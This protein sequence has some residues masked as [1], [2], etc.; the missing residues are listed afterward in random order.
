MHGFV[1]GFDVGTSGVRALA[2]DARGQVLGTGSAKLP[3]TLVTGVRREQHPDDWWYGLQA[4]CRAL[5]KQVDLTQAR[6]VA[7]DA[8][9]G[10]ILPVDESSAPLAAGRMY[11]DADTGD[12]AA[13]IAQLA[14]QESAAH[15]ATS[16]AAR[17]LGWLDLPN[18]HCILHQADW[19]NRKLGSEDFVTDENNALKTGYDPVARTWPAW[20]ES[21]GLPHARLPKVVPVGTPIGKIDAIAAS[22]L[23]IPAG[24]TLAAGTTDG[25]ATFLASGASR[26]GEGSTALGSTIVLKLLSDHPIFAPQYGIY[27]HRLG[28]QWLAGGASNCGGKTLAA[29]FAEDE[30]VALSA[31]LDVTQ[32]TNLDYYPLP[33]KGERFPI[34]DAEL[35]PRLTPRPTDDATFLHAIL[36]G[37]ARVEKLGYTRLAELGGPKLVS[38]RHAGGGSRNAAWMQLRAQHL[39]VPL[40]DAWSDEAAAGSARLA[41]RALGHELKLA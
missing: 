27:S 20:L 32:P 26:T 25:C 40:A 29:L 34:A 33:S 9:S 7:L 4:A 30:I 23:G 1:L 21:F 39:G 10:T 41:W 6:A 12:L 16:P 3:P 11:D 24:I 22:F 28:D 35:A 17:A 19:L 14:P 38:V 37:F 15:G 13:R 31:K 5:G 2:V 8:T 36:E 18:L